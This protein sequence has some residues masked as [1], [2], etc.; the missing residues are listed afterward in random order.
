MEKKVSTTENFLQFVDQPH[1]MEVIIEL[2]LDG[3]NI[4]YFAK[5]TDM[6]PK[7]V[8]SGDE[9]ISHIDVWG[10]TLKKEHISTGQT[11]YFVGNGRIAIGKIDEV[12]V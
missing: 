1:A 2:E 9:F 8:I 7:S 10:T 5:I 12:F 3:Q 4:M 11:I 6:E